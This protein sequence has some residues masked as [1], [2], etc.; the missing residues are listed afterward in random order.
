MYPGRIFSSRFSH[1]L[2]HFVLLS[3]PFCVF[4]FKLFFICIIKR[5]VLLF[6]ICWWSVLKKKEI[7]S[8]SN[9]FDLNHVLLVF[10]H[11]FCTSWNRETH[12]SFI[13][14]EVT[15][16]SNISAIS[17]FLIFRFSFCS[18]CLVTNY[19]I[20]DFDAWA[21]RNLTS[22]RSYDDKKRLKYFLFSSFILLVQ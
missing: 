22:I 3:P 5:E 12:L 17:L 16:S 9:Y 6:F 7:T 11:T 1:I 19:V 8:R 2:S 20:R 13:S 18:E 4:S 21:V 14:S 15:L 10:I